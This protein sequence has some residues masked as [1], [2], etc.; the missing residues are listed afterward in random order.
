MPL[1]PTGQQTIVEWQYPGEEKQRIVGVDDYSVKKDWQFETTNNFN[2]TFTAKARCSTSS[3]PPGVAPNVPRAFVTGQEIEIFIIG[4]LP[5]PIYGTEK[6]V[7]SP[8]VNINI[9]FLNRSGGNLAVADCAK[10]TIEQILYTR[11]ATGS[12]VRVKSVAGSYSEPVVYGDF[13][14]IKFVPTTTPPRACIAGVANS[15]IF[16]ITQNGNVVYQ[17]IR[18]VCPIVTYACGE[19]CPDGSCECTNGS[20]VCCYDPST[21]RV[22][23]SFT[24]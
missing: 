12:A 7:V 21:G 14:D 19:Q 13:Y 18:D 24:R 15:C 11:S 17:K 10:R 1:C 4:S 5:G 22:V 23:K 3:P 9:T 6:I 8:N 16:T 2:Y 20:T